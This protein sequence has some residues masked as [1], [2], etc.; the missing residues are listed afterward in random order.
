M[1]QCGFRLLRRRAQEGLTLK[2]SGGKV[3]GWI[4]Q[5]EFSRR[6]LCGL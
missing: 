1:T 5:T 3:G 6:I 4:S 2:L